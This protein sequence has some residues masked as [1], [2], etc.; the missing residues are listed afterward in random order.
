[1]SAT[2]ESV[3]RGRGRPALP[4]EEKARRRKLRKY[5]NKNPAPARVENKKL[6]RKED[7]FENS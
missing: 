1:V 3:K 2:Q 5:S 4:P 6:T 7:S